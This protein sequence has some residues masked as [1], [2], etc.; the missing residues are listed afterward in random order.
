MATFN[1]STVTNID[2]LTSK[3]GNDTY[4]VNAGGYLTVD[5]DSRFGTNNNTSAIMGNITLSTSGGSIEFKGTT[6]RLIPFSSGSGTVPASNT[7]ISSASGSGK[8]IAVYASLDVAPTA[9]AAAMPATGYIKIKQTTGSFS[10]SQA[11]SGITATASG[12]DQ[13]GW[14][15]IVGADSA[16]AT[17][18]R[19]N[20]FIVT[21]DWYT[22]LGTTTTGTRATTY[23]IPNNGSAVCYFPGVWVETAPSSGT[24]EFY[25][26]AG[27]LSALAANISTDT[28]R[29]K[30]C[31]ISTAGLLRFGHDGTNSTGGY[32][33][34]SGCKIRI[35]NVFFTC[36][37]SGAP[38]VNVLPNATLATRF[39]FTTTGGG[40]IS[41]T[42]ASMNWYLSLAQPYSVSLVNSS[43]QTAINLSEVA[44]TTTITNVGIGQE[45]ANTQFGLTMSTCYAGGTVTDLVVTRATLASSGNYTATLSDMSGFTFT[46]LKLIALAYRANATTGAFTALRLSNCTF[47]NPLLIGGKGL[48]TTCSY[49]TF[50][51]STYLD[52][53]SGTTINNSF[54]QYCY[55]LAS[56]CVTCTFNGLSFSDQPMV[57]PYNGLFNI[58]AAACNDIKIRSI[59]TFSNPLNLGY[60][61]FYNVPWSRALTTGF[62]YHPS[63]HIMKSGDGFYVLSSSDIAAV[64]VGSK[65]VIT[66]PAV[67]ATGFSFTCLN[68]GATT[69]LLSYFAT[70]TASVLVIDASANA[71]NID[72]QRVYTD[73]CRSVSYSCDNS[74]KN[75]LLESVYANPILSTPVQAGLNT[76]IKNTVSTPPLT[77]QTAVYGTHFIDYHVQYLPSGSTTNIPW[78]RTTTVA[79][80]TCIDHNMYTNCVI[81]V[82]FSSDAAAIVTGQK[83]VT[84]LDKDKFT[85]TCLNAG[86]A[87]GTLSF[88]PLVSRMAVQMN[89]ASP[90]TLS[91]YTKSG[92]TT[93]NSAGGLIMTGANVDTITFETPYY[94][95][96][97]T[98]FSLSD[99]VVNGGVTV[100]GFNMYYQLDR[101]TGYGPVRNFGYHI[102]TNGSSAVNTNTLSVPSTVGLQTGDYVWGTNIASYAK[103]TGFNSNTVYLD[104]VHVGTVASATAC[105][106]CYQY[107][108]TGINP[109][110][111]FKQK[112]TIAS[113]QTATTPITSLYYYLDSSNATRSIEYPLDT[114]S[115]GLYLVG[116][117]SGTEVRVYDSST[118]ALLTGTDA[119]TSSTFVYNYTWTGVN[120]SAYI[121]VLKTGYQ[122]LRYTDQSLGQAGL[123]IPVFQTIDR[124]YFN[125]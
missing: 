95:L 45:A 87:T 38:T 24:Y 48:L 1:I 18:N 72:V 43:F 61:G 82:N 11:L 98:G 86:A 76:T 70:N 19:L 8:L 57:G 35:P 92:S 111:G 5:Q 26:C 9:A 109:N 28:T 71:N 96:G 91:Y 99:T 29:G 88:F 36:S 23:Q 2:T 75:I 110:I 62:I 37:T 69:G 60:S 41:I 50:N 121:T 124:N 7:T 115:T 78:Q 85:F 73:S 94:V 120:N 79:T 104:R 17:V 77:A 90:D 116:L 51:N 27:S 52:K 6:V 97:Y 4:N 63:G 31:W 34:V 114:V 80:G 39:D 122:W 67:T 30:F 10:N 12:A 118:D 49:C 14:I 65:T 54:G 74:S 106:F 101:G 33:P 113:T 58:A 40:V 20:S 25:P 103:V 100:S 107:N 21:G 66:P 3:A 108:E 81:G 105:K 123:T 56:S 68:A 59:G 53:L 22:F 42:N 125:P 84:V 44:S 112:L 13:P 119:V 46:N 102:L 16:T 89:E 83:T 64:T 93:F 32:C 15:E 55:T 117:Q 47:T